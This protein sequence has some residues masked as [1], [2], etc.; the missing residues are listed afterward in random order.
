MIKKFKKFYKQKITWRPYFYKRA[1]KSYYFL[2]NHK[3]FVTRKDFKK[4]KFKAG[5]DFDIADVITAQQTFDEIFVNECYRFGCCKEKEI[6]IDAGANI[7]IFSLY[8]LIKNR[9][10]RIYSIEADPST[11]QI[12]KKNIDSNFL[13][14]QIKCFNYA[15]CSKNRTIPFFSSPASGWSSILNTRGA[16]DGRCVE[17]N[18]ISLSTFLKIN[19]ICNTPQFLDQ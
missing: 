2:E 9:E 14:N 7:G 15:L 8:A 19:E 4:F 6:I 13:E 11:F 17:I 3:E 12:L 16:R 18:A 5:Y 10:A 1:L